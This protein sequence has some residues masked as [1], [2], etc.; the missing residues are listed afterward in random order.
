MLFLFRE[1][2]NRVFEEVSLLGILDRECLCCLLV[3][4]HLV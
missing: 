3:G 4:R 2:L 1:K